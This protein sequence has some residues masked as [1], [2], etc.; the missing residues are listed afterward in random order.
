MANRTRII[1]NTPNPDARAVLCRSVNGTETNTRFEVNPTGR[2]QYEV[3]IQQF[4]KNPRNKRGVTR[5]IKFITTRVGI[6]HICSV[7]A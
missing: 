1:N 6:D 3:T 5:T 2:G 7:P 4:E